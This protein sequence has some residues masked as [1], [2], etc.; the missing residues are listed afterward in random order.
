VLLPCLWIK[1]WLGSSFEWRGNHMR[2]QE[3]RATSIG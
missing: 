1:A 2:V 3:S